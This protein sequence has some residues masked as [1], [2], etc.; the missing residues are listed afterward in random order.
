[1]STSVALRLTLD[2]FNRMVADGA[3]DELRGKRIELIYGELREV[4]PPGPTHAQAVARLLRWSTNQV[5][6]DQATIRIQDPIEIPDHDSA[7]QPDVVWV[8]P[9]DYG[10][11]HPQPRDILLVIEVADSSVAEDMGEMAE[12][13]ARAGIKDYWVINV[14]DFSIEVFRSPKRGRYSE[15]RKYQIGERI[16]PLAFPK[17]SLSVSGLFSGTL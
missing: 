1:M 3:F 6:E 7:P 14:P 8:K 17:V 11:Q 12:L 2:D 16:H 13:Y 4:T 9:K 5:A 10:K 15:R